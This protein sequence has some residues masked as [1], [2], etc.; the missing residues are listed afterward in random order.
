MR[1]APSRRPAADSAA[2]TPHSQPTQLSGQYRRPDPNG[3]LERDSQ[4]AV[5]PWRVGEVETSVLDAHGISGPQIA[6]GAVQHLPHAADDQRGDVDAVRW[7]GDRVARHYAGRPR[8]QQPLMG[9]AS[10]HGVDGDADG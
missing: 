10:K 2:R 6:V 7:M 5:T 8:L 9:I 1:G 3:P 4:L